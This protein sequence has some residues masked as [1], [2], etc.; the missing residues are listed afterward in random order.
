M[1]GKKQISKVVDMPAQLYLSFEL[2][3]QDW[4]LGFT[5]GLGQAQDGRARLE[6]T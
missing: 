2:G 1:S 6:S 3:E 4:T 5:V